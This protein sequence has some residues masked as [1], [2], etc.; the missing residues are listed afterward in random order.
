LLVPARRA[1]ATRIYVHAADREWVARPDDSIV[2]WS[3]DATEIGD[4]LTLINVG[5]HFSGG[6]VLHWRDGENGKGALLSGDI[7]QVVADRR[8]VSFMYSYPKSHPRAA[9]DDS[10][11]AAPGGTLSIREGVRRLVESHRVSIGGFW[12][13]AAGIAVRMV[14]ERHIPTATAIAFGGATAANVL[15]VPAG[16]LIGELTNWRVAFVA[17]AGLGLLVVVGLLLLLPAMP[18]MPA[19]QPVRLRTLREQFRNPVVRA[20][21]IATFLLVG[22]HFTAFTF[23]APRCRTSPGSTNAW[24]AR[25]CC[26]S[27][28]P[29]SRAI[30]SRVRRRGATSVR[31]S[32]PS[33]CCS[34]SRWRCSR[35]PGV[36]GTRDLDDRA[37]A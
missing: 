27:V 22:G 14:P 12:A 18:A 3:G 7:F 17:L 35:S 10:P 11:C 5:V 25:Y 37:G 20:G 4:G 19:T 16:T 34:R 8:H 24:S 26:A 32:S 33:A 13:L 28:P 23:V 1:T 15:G 36:W 9:S 31:R 2:F 30:S 6:Q 21:I 29:A